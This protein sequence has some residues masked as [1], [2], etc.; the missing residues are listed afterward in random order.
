MPRCASAPLHEAVECIRVRELSAEEHT[1]LASLL[2]RPQRRSMSLRVDISRIDAYL[3][4]TRLASSLRE[5]WSTSDG[6]A[7]HLTRARLQLQTLWSGVIDECGRPGLADL[8]G[9]PAG[10]GLLKLLARQGLA[11]SARLRHHTD[12]A[13]RVS[14]RLPLRGQQIDRTQLRDDLFPLWRF[15]GTAVLLSPK[16]W[17]ELIAGGTRKCR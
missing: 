7:P 11:A 9:S 14:D 16:C 12:Q 17:I 13:D 3:R 5:A 1:A 8:V 4:R 15:F 2:G 10:L 6:P